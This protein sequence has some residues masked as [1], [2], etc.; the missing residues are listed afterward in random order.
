MRE[1]G[2]DRIGALGERPDGVAIGCQLLFQ[3]LAGWTLHQTT[4]NNVA[5]LRLGYL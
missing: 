3:L 4:T 1:L 5:Q 2:E